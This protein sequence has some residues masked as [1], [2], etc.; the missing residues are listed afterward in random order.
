MLSI[1]VH[2]SNPQ[3]SPHPLS[4]IPWDACKDNHKSPFGGA[5][6]ISRMQTFREMEEFLWSLVEV[7]A[8][9]GLERKNSFTMPDNNNLI[10]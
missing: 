7:S 4:A 5:E 9:Q 10:S 8:D 6:R 2:K 1:V 3:W